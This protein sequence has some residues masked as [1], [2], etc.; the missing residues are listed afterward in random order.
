MFFGDAIADAVSETLA[1][2]C[3]LSV[4]QICDVASG[5]RVRTALPSKYRHPKHRGLTWSGRGRRPAWLLTY[6][7]QGGAL[8][9][10]RI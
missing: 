1:A 2:D 10:L 6:I 3:G 7:G 4:E 8:E 5:S 9:D